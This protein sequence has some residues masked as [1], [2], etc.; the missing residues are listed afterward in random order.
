M[1]ETE[2]YVIGLFHDKSSNLTKKLFSQH[3]RKKKYFVYGFLHIWSY[4]NHFWK[5]CYALIS[6]GATI[7]P[8]WR[9]AF[10]TP[11]DKYGNLNI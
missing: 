9:V 10:F 7:F 11:V 4:Q 6:H 5:K 8:K 3:F 1:P 2:T